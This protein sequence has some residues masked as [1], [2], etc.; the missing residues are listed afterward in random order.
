MKK[1]FALLLFLPAMMIAGNLFVNGGFETGD[2][3]A[4]TQGAGYW[5]GG[6]QAPADYLPGGS[7]YDMSYWQGAITDPGADPIVGALL[8]QVY[9]G[10]HSARINN[11]YNDNSVGVI[12]QTVLGYTDPK[13]YFEWA[14]VLEESHGADDSDNFTL[15]VHDDTTGAFIYNTSYSSFSAPGKFQQ[16]GSWFWTPWQVETLDVSGLSGHDFTLSLLASDCPYGGHAGYVYLDGFGST[17]I[18]PGVPEPGTIVL[19]VA[20]LGAILVGKLRKH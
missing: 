18:P 5:G 13:I 10:N 12:K 19:V 8:N 20:G 6:P 3:S 7:L 16:D 15:T 4:W 14:A 1:L 9:A 17:V 11:T 2:F